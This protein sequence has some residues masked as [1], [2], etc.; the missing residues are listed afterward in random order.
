LR[1][2][3]RHDTER[4]P[5]VSCGVFHASLPDLPFLF[6]LKRN[7]V[8]VVWLG[9]IPVGSKVCGISLRPDKASG[10]RNP[11]RAVHMCEAKS[12][13]ILHCDL[14]IRKEAVSSLTTGMRNNEI[15]NSQELSSLQL[16]KNLS[17]GY[18]KGARN[19]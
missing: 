17:Q 3:I 1:E 7:S 5:A 15:C 10:F 2:S 19:L 12:E 18:H 4:L 16:K 6:S 13:K 11:C 14:T 8:L 9:I